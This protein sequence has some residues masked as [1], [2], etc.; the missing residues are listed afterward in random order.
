MKS[1]LPFTYRDGLTIDSVEYRERARIDL[2]R[3]REKHGSLKR[4]I[5]LET[6]LDEPVSCCDDFEICI[7]MSA[8]GH[9]IYYNKW[10]VDCPEHVF[11]FLNGLESHAGWFD[12]MADALAVDGIRTYGLDRRGSG[13]NCRNFGKYQNW[14]DDVTELTRIARIENPVA[15]MHLVSICFGAKLATACAI[16]DPDR[17]DSLIYLSP[18]LSVKVS[19]TPK[20]KML[21]AIDKLPRMYFNVRTPIKNDEMFTSDGK[22]LYFLYN[23][24]LRTHSPRA[25]DF[26]Q[27]RMIDLYISKNL[28]KMTTPS[29][30]L[31]A[32]KDR[33][34]NIKKTLKVLNKFKQ[35]PKIIEYPDSD[36]VIFFGKSRDEMKRDILNYL[37]SDV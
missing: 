17:Y 25:S 4:I 33:V 13:L 21:I 26:Y 3:L 12:E 24:K 27:A 19:P 28:D 20:E 34:I 37:V 30:A 5:R 8:D 2:E 35:K 1:H 10:K 23:D 7:F 32:G 15:K 18:G 29:L 36:H 6:V 31:L 14:I 16:Q 11:V 22:A 9:G